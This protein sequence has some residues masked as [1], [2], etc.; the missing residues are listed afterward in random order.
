[1]KYIAH[2]IDEKEQTV[3]D[4]LEETAELAKNNALEPFKDLAYECGLLHDIGKYTQSFQ[5]RIRGDNKKCEHAICGA[6]W[7]ND[8]WSDP[9]NALMEYCIAGHH[10]GLPDG[11]KKTDTADS[12][13]LSGRMKRISEDFSEFENE[14][15]PEIPNTK[16][17]F[18]YLSKQKNSEDLV[19]IY[20]FMTKYVF[21][22]LTDA[23][24]LNTERF[25]NENAKRGMSGDFKKAREK[26]QE[27]LKSFKSDT[28]VN[29]ARNDLLNQAIENSEDLVDINILNM[30]TGS[31]K[32]LCSLK[33]ALDY[34]VNRNKKRIIYVI[35]YTSIIEQTADEFRKIFGNAM[36][37]L[38]H[39]SNFDY[40][41]KLGKNSDNISGEI[42]EENELTEEKLRRTCENWDAPFIV[43]TSVQFFQSL[44]HY[45][46]SRLRKL[47][48]MADSLIVFDEIHL[49]P[50]DLLQPC[51]RGIGF[52]T[53]YLN[54]EAIF[55]S[56]TMP[57][58]S[59]LFKAYLPDCKTKEL[60]LD[61]SEFDSFSNC[62]YIN[63]GKCSLEK[64]VIKSCDYTSS[65]IIVNSRKSARD[66]YKLLDGKKYHLTT[67][68]TPSHRSS[69]IANI[70]QAL[71][72]NE[73]ITVVSTSLVEAG[74]DLDFEAVFR[75]LAGLDSIL[76]SGGRCNREGLRDS[77]D[78]FIFETEENSPKEIGVR[79]NIV[80]NMLSEYN[81]ISTQEAVEDYYE[82]LFGFK[83]KKINSCSIASFEGKVTRPEQIPFRKFAE[84]FEFIKDDTIAVVIDNCEET[85]ELLKSLEYGSMSAKRSLQRYSVALRTGKSNGYDNE[86][87][88]MLKSGLIAPQEDLFVLTNN[89]Y[90][91]DDIGLVTEPVDYLV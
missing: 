90:Y 11:G 50:I 91:K 28:K 35:P 81:D 32:T 20:A 22:C 77:G 69:V 5:C 16:E 76:Q 48:N 54:S 70:K 75:E 74:V 58:Y 42:D 89:D 62:K 65:L 24:Y 18:S 45:K 29:K 88:I 39:H 49:L 4:H 85:H 2:K 59:N 3:K 43:T 64:V 23:D 72:N 36:P 17:I 6:Q 41:K 25:Y 68:M 13:S 55:L 86:F 40:D 60:I 10:T 38:E 33:I 79:A 46:G 21:S 82:R 9:F 51:L 78:V 47:H 71:K 19:E 83:K 73:K 84:S 14:I 80:R 57:N 63:L 26:L 8:N 61:K 53:K 1:M 67:Y 34:A 7:I 12:P 52:I 37:I 31:G 15:T 27:K 56:A 87:E 44:Y 66:V 30:P